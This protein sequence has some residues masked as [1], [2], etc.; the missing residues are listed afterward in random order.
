MKSGIG[1]TDIVFTL[2][3]GGSGGSGGSGSGGSGGVG[4]VGGVIWG[5]VI[6]PDTEREYGVQVLSFSEHHVAEMANDVAEVFV[7]D[8]VLLAIVYHPTELK[9]YV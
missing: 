4:G 6:V 2:G 5:K 1:W 7:T 3:V 8:I 9:L